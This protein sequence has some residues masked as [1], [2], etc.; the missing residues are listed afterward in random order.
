[1]K[2]FK[3]FQKGV[4]LGGWFSQGEHSDAHYQSFITEQDFAKI[5][6][7]GLDHVRV[8]VD[9]E[10]FENPGGFDYLRRTQSLCEKYGLRMV[11]DLHKTYGYSFD[12][13][14]REEGFFDSAELQEKFFHLWE[15][16]AGIFGHF[17]DRMA[18]ELL[19]EVTDT[20][21]SDK[22][23]AIA[24][25]CVR[26]IR[27]LAPEVPILIGGCH[28][29]S[30]ATLPALDMPYDEHIVYNFHCYEPLLFTHQGA[31]WVDRM[32]PDFRLPFP[33]SSQEYAEAARSLHL[34][35][36]DMAAESATVDAS[37]FDTLFAGAVKLAQERDVA[38]YCGEYGVIGL[39]DNESTVN[40]Y[41]AIHSA[42]EKYGIGRAAWNYKE[43]DFGILD[44][45]EETAREVI[46]LL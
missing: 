15:Q 29:N 28:N 10:L 13:G 37:L 2:V 4:D 44:L 20:K 24:R 7:W 22:W 35:L 32:K 21:Y 23:N 18:F 5:A 38:L 36:R 3:G 14:E 8:P 6:S 19:N 31:Y 45:P 42:F 25:E 26:R 27:P 17:K 12:S 30:I 41:R 40:W 39:A 46:A 11:L 34:P 33:V 1:M 43:K 16:L 9:Y